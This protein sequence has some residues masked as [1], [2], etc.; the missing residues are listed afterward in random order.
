MRL[1]VIG[2]TAMDGGGD[3]ATLRSMMGMVTGAIPGS[4]LVVNRDPLTQNGD[5]LPHSNFCQTI[6]TN[7]SSL[8]QIIIPNN[9]GSC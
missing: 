1:A 3:L 7:L 8:C 5:P 9:I 6:L 2:V 4:D